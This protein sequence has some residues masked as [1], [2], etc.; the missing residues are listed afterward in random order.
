MA[1]KKSGCLHDRVEEIESEGGAVIAKVCRACG[2]RFALA[3]CEVCG[4]DFFRTMS[5][6]AV[7]VCS[8]DC[9]KERDKMRKK[10]ANASA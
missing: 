2:A 3:Q 9:R 5:G 1:R 6:Y 8:S 7:R 4:K 10:N